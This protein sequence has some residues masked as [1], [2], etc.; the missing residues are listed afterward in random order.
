MTAFR[1][2]LLSI[3]II[4]L[5]IFVFPIVMDTLNFGNILGILFFVICIILTVYSHQTSEIIAHLWQSIGGKIAVI[6]IGAVIAALVVLA[7]FLSGLMIKA[8]CNY[9]EG[10]TTVIVLGCKVKGDQPSRM[11]RHRLDAA[12]E[13]LCENE[14]A[15][16]IVSGGQGK[17]EVMSEAE[18][19]YG[20]LINKGISANRLYMEDKSENTEQNLKFSKKIIDERKLCGD[21]TIVTNG[22]HQY[23]ASYIAK[24]A[25]FEKVFSIPAKTEIPYIPTYWVREWAAILGEWI[26]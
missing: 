7:L 3:E 20:Y 12:Y 24:K 1:Y 21:I 17:D 10:K 9:P 5:F 8:R 4:G 18:C 15:V 13:Y 11:L 16:C 26:K 19:M 23:R 25:G 2:T 14:D 22:F 6:A